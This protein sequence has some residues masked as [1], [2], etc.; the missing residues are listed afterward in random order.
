M[1]LFMIMINLVII[2]GQFGVFFELKMN[3]MKNPCSM[4]DFGDVLYKM[5]VKNNPYYI[6]RNSLPT[7]EFTTDKH[8]KPMNFNKLYNVYTCPNGWNMNERYLSSSF[9]TESIKIHTQK[10]RYPYSLNDISK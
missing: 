10:V 2:F 5:L 7:R 8:K 3:E 4:D 1:I 9:K 6:S